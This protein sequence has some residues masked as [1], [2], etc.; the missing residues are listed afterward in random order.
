MYLDVLPFPAE[1]RAGWSEGGHNASYGV[2]SS[3]VGSLSAG[4]KMKRAG[5]DFRVK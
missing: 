3:T 5:T 1:M 4:F 2:S